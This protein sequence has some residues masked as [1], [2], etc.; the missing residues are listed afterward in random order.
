MTKLAAREGH[1]RANQPTFSIKIYWGPLGVSW[2]L[3][4]MF[5]GFLECLVGVPWGSWGPCGP[6]PP[7]R[8]EETPKNPFQKIFKKSKIDAHT[9]HTTEHTIH[10]TQ[11]TT[12]NTQHTTHNTFFAD[13]HR[14]GEYRQKMK[15]L[16]TAVTEK[17]LAVDHHAVKQESHNE[18]AMDRKGS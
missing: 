17:K 4:K 5:W 9:T 11:H 15:M 6:F 8:A 10:N 14:Q 13:F 3:L 16:R 1:R 7:K 2:G 12:H 18:I